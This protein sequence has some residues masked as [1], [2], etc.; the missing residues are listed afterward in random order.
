MKKS[1]ARVSALLLAVCL[2]LGM[3]P[4]AVAAD[5]PAAGPVVVN[6]GFDD[7]IEEEGT[8]PGWRLNVLNLTQEDPNYK[9]A[10]L[11]T[12]DGYRGNYLE[13]TKTVNNEDS[14]GKQTAETHAIAI[15]GG[16]EYTLY[17]GHKGD[18]DFS[19]SF[20][21]HT[22]T[23]TA[24]GGNFTRYPAASASAWARREVTFTAPATAASVII[25]MQA[26]HYGKYNRIDN[27]TLIEGK[28]VEQPGKIVYE[29]LQKK[30]TGTTTRDD[31]VS[32]KPYGYVAEKLVSSFDTFDDVPY[33][34]GEVDPATLKGDIDRDMI[35]TAN[36]LGNTT[37]KLKIT[38]TAE[39]ETT[40]I[41]PQPYSANHY[42][43]FS[44]GMVV[45]FYADTIGEGG[46]FTLKLARKGTVLA[47]S[48][49]N[50]KVTKYGS[51]IKDSGDGI[52]Y[53]RQAMVYTQ[54][55]QDGNGVAGG[56]LELVLTLTGDSTVYVDNF[57]YMFTVTQHHY[58]PGFEYLFNDTLPAVW[59]ALYDANKGT[60]LPTE[61]CIGTEKEVRNGITYGDNYLILPKGTSLVLWKNH[62][63]WT[64]PFYIH[65]TLVAPA[66]V[67]VTVDEKIAPNQES[68]NGLVIGG[69]RT[70]Y[71]GSV[72]T[73]P[74]SVDDYTTKTA[75]YLM[76]GTV[77]FTDYATATL[78]A[79]DATYYID[80]VRFEML[81]D[82]GIK[83]YDEDGTEVT[84]DVLPKGKLTLSYTKPNA[85][86]DTGGA[87]TSTFSKFYTAADGTTQLKYERTAK[88][89]TDTKWMKYD[90][91]AWVDAT[92]AEVNGATV[93]DK[94]SVVTA[95]Y[96]IENGV[97]VLDSVVANTSAVAKV[98]LP[99]TSTAGVTSVGIMPLQTDHTITLD[100]GTDYEV[101]TMVWDSIGTMKPVNM[102][103]FTT[104][105]AAE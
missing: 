86:A 59:P 5:E 18:T 1:Y 60:T 64:T 32:K 16:K 28:P 75:Y 8:I 99:E 89:N 52:D 78:D 71:L 104:V 31:A 55:G 11:K 33:V 105:E 93:G 3:L 7:A 34:S 46:A 26:N 44:C 62:N 14:D 4:F 41:I 35:D 50:S 91:A 47:E 90:G 57:K 22:A 73:Q 21:F 23:G 81:K 76:P 43:G 54:N 6:G 51:F 39:K 87:N 82:E 94:Y 102:Y 66:H 88:G 58:N 53:W 84:G 48:A 19:L 74:A 98:V 38:S 92:L 15:E 30:G 63:Y 68:N 29:D 101:K 72:A 79:A 36:I 45:D 13:L 67:K 10:V 85:A 83:V 40:I 70:T 65:Q 61:V 25:N 95:V 27:V 20:H 100:E 80:N 97:R 37:G 9:L 24:A 56:A 49:A 103:A 69:G 42:C 77:A 12:E 96:K 17:F 2:M